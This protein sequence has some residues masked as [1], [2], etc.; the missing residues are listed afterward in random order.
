MSGG[1]R[2]R[3]AQPPSERGRT[4]GANERD[5]SQ[6]DMHCETA[7]LLSVDG[8][9]GDQLASQAAAGLLTLCAVPLPQNAGGSCNRLHCGQITA[10]DATLRNAAPD[11]ARGGRQRPGRR[12]PPTRGAA[13]AGSRSAIQAAGGGREGRSAGLLQ[14]GGP[15]A[16]RRRHRWRLQAMSCGPHL[17]PIPHFSASRRDRHTSSRMTIAIINPLRLWLTLLLHN[18]RRARCRRLQT[19]VALL[20]RKAA[21]VDHPSAFVFVCRARCRRRWR[22][23]AST[24]RR[25][26]RQR[27]TSTSPTTRCAVHA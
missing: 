1:G 17:A 2:R 25:P 7:E 27:L 3:R 5:L 12:L 13:A 4:I 8:C 20:L 26:P 6:F 10:P 24:M 15:A 19:H 23:P 9:K 18:N 11:H 22:L 16:Q 14:P 21:P